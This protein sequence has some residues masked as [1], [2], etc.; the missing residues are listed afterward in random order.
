MA[1]MRDDL[2]GQDLYSQDVMI[3]T[4]VMEGASGKFRPFNF[5]TGPGVDHL[6]FKVNM[7]NIALRAQAAKITRVSL[8]DHRD[9][10]WANNIGGL[11]TEI[12]NADIDYQ[13]QDEGRTLKVWVRD[14]Q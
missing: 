8:I 13:L 3:V 5:L 14:P 12:R 10:A 4:K 7:E 2:Y 1:W 9:S 11:V 6:T